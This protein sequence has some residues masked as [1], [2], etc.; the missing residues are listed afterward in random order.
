MALAR[1]GQ[2]PH[3]QLG[4]YIRFDAY[5]LRVWLERHHKAPGRT[6]A[7]AQIADGD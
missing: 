4:A 5:E 2:I 1:G 3:Y 6:E 7:P